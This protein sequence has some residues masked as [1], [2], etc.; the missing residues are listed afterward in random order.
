MHTTKCSMTLLLLC[1]LINIVV[2]VV[3]AGVILALEHMKKAH[4]NCDRRTAEIVALKARIE[5]LNAAIVVCQEKLPV[6][7]APVTRQVYA[8]GWC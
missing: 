5:E 8:C 2:M 6:S 4:T 7:G 3:T 1:Y